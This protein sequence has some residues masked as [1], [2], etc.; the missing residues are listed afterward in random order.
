MSTAVAIG[1]GNEEAQQTIA[2]LDSKACRQY[3]AHQGCTVYW[4]R[5]GDGPPLVLIH[6]GHGNWM[7][8]IRNIEVLAQEHTLWIPDLPG[9]GDS[10]DLASHAHASD[11][12]ERLLGVVMATLD[13][14][15]DPEAVIDLAGFSFGGLVAA[16]LAVQRA[17]VRR[18]AL[19]GTAGHG[20]ARRE[21]MDMVNWRLRDRGLMLD[22]LKHNLRALMLH[23]PDSIDAVAMA[24][25]EV[26]SVRTRFRSKFFSRTAGLPG[27]F[28]AFRQPL[29]MI[30]GEHDATAVPEDAAERLA[31]N[32]PERQW[33]LVPRAGHWVQYERAKDVNR[34][35]QR[36]FSP[37]AAVDP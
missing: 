9:F 23:D 3:I 8:W 37:S 22:A 5:F 28:E 14:L 27:A 21:N 20:G 24:V 15:V 12:L 25:Q 10:T 7:H 18:L 4:R 32:H 34:L 31:K 30:W 26:A 16:H 19:L 1:I 33:C 29:L 35:L 11:R 17:G 2:G 6:G 13:V 36:W